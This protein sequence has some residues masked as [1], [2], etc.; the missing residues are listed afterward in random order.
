MSQLQPRGQ[1]HGHLVGWG[2]SK[3]LRRAA[4][5]VMADGADDVAGALQDL[6]AA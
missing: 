3:V 4:A 6:L 2:D 5:H 1:V